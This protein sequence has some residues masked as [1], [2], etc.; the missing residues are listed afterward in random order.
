MDSLMKLSPRFQ[1]IH[2]RIVC[3]IY[4]RVSMGSPLIYSLD[5]SRLGSALFSFKDRAQLAATES[6]FM[7]VATGRSTIEELHPGITYDVWKRRPCT[8]RVIIVPC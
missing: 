4:A 6:G 3:F 8:W 7:A 5:N 1:R 2:C